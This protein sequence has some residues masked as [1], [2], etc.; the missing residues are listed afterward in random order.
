MPEETGKI[1]DEEGKFI[2]GVSGNP[3]GRPP[4]SGISITTE[5][6]RKL[7]EMNPET[8]KTNLQTLL[9]VI[10]ESAVKKKDHQMIKQIW[11]YI[12]GMPQAKTDITSGGRPIPILDSDVY[13]DNSDKETTTTK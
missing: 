1:R 12:D 13:K 6:K 7:E 10:L 5:I 9:E 3:D 11:N 8:K 2:K 4:G